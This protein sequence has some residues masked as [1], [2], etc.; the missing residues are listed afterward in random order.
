[1]SETPRL[2]VFLNEHEPLELGPPEFAPQLNGKSPTAQPLGNEGWIPVELLTTEP[3]DYMERHASGVK[4]GGE[5]MYHYRQP[6]WAPTVYRPSPPLPV[7]PPRPPVPRAFGPGAGMPPEPFGP[8]GRP[9]PPAEEPIIEVQGP[10]GSD[11]EVRPDEFFFG[12]FSERAT[13][14]SNPESG[15]EDKPP[16]PIKPTVPAR[17]PG[18]AAAAE[19]AGK[20][21]PDEEEGDATPTPPRGFQRPNTGAGNPWGIRLPDKHKR[22]YE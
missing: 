7:A 4:R 12:G 13:P 14:P 8:K 20:F 3:S 19:A 11:E 16:K 22:R 2:H 18:A 21:A 5:E 15:N 17:P 1:M 9:S 10:V 6:G